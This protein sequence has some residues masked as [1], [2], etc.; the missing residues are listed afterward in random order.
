MAAYAARFI[1][2]HTSDPG[3]GITENYL[4]LYVMKLRMVWLCMW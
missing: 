4:T 3:S 1:H 2:D